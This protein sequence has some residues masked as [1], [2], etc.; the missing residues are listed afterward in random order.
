MARDT[1]LES[2][3]A[4][5]LAGLEP[6]D[7][8]RMFGGLCWMWRGNLLCG[9]DQQ[10]LLLRLGKG[11]DEGVLT[12]P[13]VSPMVMGGKRMEGWIRLSPA[14]AGDATLRHRLLALAQDFVAT[15]PA[16]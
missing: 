9:A 4:G 6:L 1:A 12:E 5:D 13:G 8:R 10:G 3:I 15:L 7:R 16:K 2:L 11:R 14:A